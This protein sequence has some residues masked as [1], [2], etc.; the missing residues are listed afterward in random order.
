M[1]VGHWRI[2]TQGGKTEVL[3][4]KTVALPNRKRQILYVLEPGAKTLPLDQI[5]RRL[6][7]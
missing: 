4:D 7:A 3:R 5:G 6:T 2:D 1:S